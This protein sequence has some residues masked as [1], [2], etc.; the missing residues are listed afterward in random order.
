MALR[1]HRQFEIQCN[2]YKFEYRAI[3]TSQTNNDFFYKRWLESSAREV[4]KSIRTEEKIYAQIIEICAPIDLFWYVQTDPRGGTL[5]VSKEKLTDQNYH[6][7]VF[8][9]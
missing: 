5:Y 8:I 1:L 6:N 7:G 3:S 4:E 9:A 2:G